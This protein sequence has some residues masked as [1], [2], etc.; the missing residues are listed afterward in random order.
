MAH[1]A[2]RFTA[3]VIQVLFCLSLLS[4]SACSAQTSDSE[5]QYTA[6]HQ[7]ES[8]FL[9]RHRVFNVRLPESYFENSDQTYPV[10][11]HIITDREA[12]ELTRETARVLAADGKI[13]EMIVVSLHQDGRNRADI[14]PTIEGSRRNGNAEAYLE[15]L[16]K[17]AVPFLA[18]TYRT[19]DERIFAGWS[20]FGAFATFAVTHKPDL[21]SS[22]IVRSSAGQVPSEVLRSKMQNM[23]LQ[24][25]NLSMS[26]HMSIGTEGN[27]NRR[28]DQFNELR[29][30]LEK[31]APSDF[32]WKAEIIDAAGHSDT[33]QP[34]LRSGLVFHFQGTE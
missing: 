25:P 24:T 13:P 5:D 32:R 2:K 20:R 7:L 14:R 6:R 26:F 16:E 22:V 29:A 17:D 21:F 27:E 1:T 10:L 9:T 4:F 3:R 12:I 28:R 30:V 34:G 23:L 15:Y 8:E 18:S 31:E 11:F 33:F 19:S